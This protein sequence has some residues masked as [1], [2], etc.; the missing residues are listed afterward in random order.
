MNLYKTSI[1]W[2]ILLFILTYIPMYAQESTKNDKQNWIMLY[3]SN[4]YYYE[5]REYQKASICLEKILPQLEENYRNITTD[6]TYAIG[7]GYLVYYY[8]KLKKYSNLE[9]SY[10]KAIQLRKERLG[11]THT[12]YANS[13]KGLASFYG[14]QGYFLK[15]ISLLKQTR[16]LFEDKDNEAYITIIHTL[17][18]AYLEQRNYSKAEILLLEIREISKE[19]LGI[20]SIWHGRICNTIGSLYHLQKEYF[21]S[22]QFFLEAKDIYINLQDSLQYARVCNNLGNI[23]LEQ[24]EYD[25]ARPFLLEARNIRKKILGKKHPQYAN[26]CHNVAGLY[27]AIKDYKKAEALL[28]EAKNIISEVI[29][30]KHP[31]YAIIC[32]T[33]GIIYTHEKQ[34]QKAEEVLLEGLKILEN[35]FGK[36]NERYQEI[37]QTL[38]VLYKN[39]GKTQEVEK[40]EKD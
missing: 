22:E 26:S 14:K 20:E 32:R 30:K 10:L 34:Y 21:K 17:A 29:G 25:K 28:L 18:I 1:I 31:H 38:I 40:W 15:A 7:F 16:N 39:Q 35:A 27:M 6:T 23:Y 37:K 33:L 11:Q 5:K 9:E 12:E 13:V 19:I 8:N 2:I 24:Q 36:N 4:F 3:D